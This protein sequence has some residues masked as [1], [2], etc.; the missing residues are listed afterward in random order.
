MANEMTAPSAAPVRETD[1]LT[2]DEI[3]ALIGD[4]ANIESHEQALEIIETLDTEI[5]NIQVQIDMLA[6]ESN[7]R[8][9]PP[10]RQNWLRRASYAAA[11]RR[12][13]RHRVMQR[14]KEIRGTKGRAQ[15]EPKLP[16]EAKILK[17]QRLMEEAAT[18]RAAKQAD[19]LR[20]QFALQDVAQRRREL[21]EQ[22]SFNHHFVAEAKRRL[23]DETYEA[24]S[25]FAR[26][27]SPED[28][29]RG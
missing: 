26:S 29:R 12:N 28:G 17:Q 8:A 11:M 24:L 14:D 23:P 21:A 20:S 16:N 1:P 4:P 3:T 10:E 18:R 2:D 5:A 6:I 25:A 7:G 22:S 19:A 27:L 15:Q 9:L 13:E